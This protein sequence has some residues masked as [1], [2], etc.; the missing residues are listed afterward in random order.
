MKI[1]LFNKLSKIAFSVTVNL[2]RFKIVI[3]KW[4]SDKVFYYIE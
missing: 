3:R 4:L 2:F 1:K